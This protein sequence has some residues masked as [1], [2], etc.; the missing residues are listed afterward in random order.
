VKLVAIETG[1]AG[2]IVPIEEV[3]PLTGIYLPDLSASIAERYSFVSSPILAPLSELQNK[4]AEFQLGKFQA[5]REN[6]LYP[7]A[8]AR[9]GKLGADD[10][11]HNIQSL[12]IVSEGII[13][14]AWSTEAARR[15]L[16]DFFAWASDKHGLRTESEAF[17]RYFFLSQLIIEFEEPVD[18]I[19]RNFEALSSSVGK[20]FRETYGADNQFQ[21]SSLSIDYDRTILSDSNLNQLSQ[22]MVAR[23]IDKPFSSNR[24]FCQAP[25]RTED[26]IRLLEE[27]ENRLKS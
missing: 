22:F 21:F 11:E 17:S 25:L 19:I 15:F 10:G 6:E 26:H 3:L 7:L 8:S 1:R 20:T 4:G 2:I 24:F 5:A 9:L 13:A 23:Q 16:E 27:L 12:R 14:S 18:K